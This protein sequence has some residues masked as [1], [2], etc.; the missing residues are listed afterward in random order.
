[1]GLATKMHKIR[2]IF[3]NTNACAHGGQRGMPFQPN[4][5]SFFLPLFLFVPTVANP[6]PN[7]FLSVFS[8]SPCEPLPS[9]FILSFSWRLGGSS[10][11]PS[12]FILHPSYSLRLH[13]SSFIFLSPLILILANHLLKDTMFQF[14]SV[15]Q[16][17]RR[18]DENHA[19]YC[20]H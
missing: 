6:L 8:A 19:F 7:K 17:V 2:K 1:M 16:Y 15:Y 13:P 20:L 3:Q 10:L 5:F 18:R 11:H 14:P 12:S 9:P 4:K